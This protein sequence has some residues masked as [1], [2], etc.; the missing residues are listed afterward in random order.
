MLQ[1]FAHV[2]L[3]LLRVQSP[4]LGH[5]CTF[6]ICRT[7]HHIWPE[8]AQVEEGLITL[9]S[10]EITTALEDVDSVVTDASCELGVS[11]EATSAP[12]VST[13]SQEEC[14]PEVRLTLPA[15][16]VDM[17]TISRFRNLLHCG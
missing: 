1:M 13:P 11:V 17:F 8:Y 16:A 14:A 10:T 3:P 12:S 6:R 5:L 4:A 2:H 7:L 9:S 15:S